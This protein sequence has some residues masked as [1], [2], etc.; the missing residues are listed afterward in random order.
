MRRSIPFG[1]LFAA[2]ML[3]RCGGGGSSSGTPGGGNQSPAQ[4]APAVPVGLHAT[5]G[6]TQATLTW[7]ASDGATSYHVKRAPASDGT[8]TQ[9]GTSITETYADTGLTN[10]TTYY[11]AVTALNAAGESANSSQVSATPAATLAVTRP[12]YNT[13]TG[14]FVVGNKL[15]DASGAEFHI[16]GVNKL[17]WDSDSPGIPKTHANTVRWVIDFTQSTATNLSLMQWTIDNHMIPMPGNWDGTCDEGTSTLTSVVD[18]WVVQASAWKTL[19][20]YMILNI[21]NEWGPSNS[22]AWRDDYITAISRL[23]SAG[24][25]CTIAIDAGGCGQDNEDL[26]SYAKTVFDSDPQKNVIFDQHIYGNWSSGGG[27]NWQTDLATGLDRLVATGLPVVLG[28]FGPGRDIGPSPTMVT[29]GTIIQAAEARGFGW[30]A[31]AWDDPDGKW[32]N[33]PGAGDTWFALSVLGDYNSSADLT[34]FGKD[35]VEN[36]NYGLLVLAKPATIF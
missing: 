15:Y 30:M 1:V 3:A 27:E 7:T 35:V 12:A 19:E 32:S 9:I 21:A 8:Y 26:A 4:T 18:T 31:W 34:T 11:Y 25:L 22:T 5:A 29:P 14:F 16:R 6:N 24:Y 2:L 28:E 33:P 10:G 17:H 20:R 13:G 36:M 23:R